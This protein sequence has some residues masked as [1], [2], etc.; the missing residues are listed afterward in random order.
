MVIY[1]YIAMVYRKRKK[2]PLEELRNIQ[3][4]TKRMRKTRMEKIQQKERK[5]KNKS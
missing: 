1:R 2:N 3:P 4:E 5:K